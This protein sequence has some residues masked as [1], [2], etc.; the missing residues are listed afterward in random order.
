MPRLYPSIFS[1]DTFHILTYLF[2]FRSALDFH[3]HSR[4][5]DELLDYF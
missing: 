3:D 5:Y 1:R 2:F 4:L